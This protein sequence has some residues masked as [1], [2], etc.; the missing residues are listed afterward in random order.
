MMKFQFKIILLLLICICLTSLSNA[1]WTRPII[2][3]NVSNGTLFH[4]LLYNLPW[5]VAGHTIDS[6]LDMNG[7]NL[8]NVDAVR[9]IG[10]NGFIYDKEI[11]SLNPDFYLWRLNDTSTYQGGSILINGTTGEWM[12]TD[13]INKAPLF[14]VNI[15]TALTH[16]YYD[17]EINGTLFVQ[18]NLIEIGDALKDSFL[19]LDGATLK[20]D[21]G[22]NN[23]QLDRVLNMN[24]QSIR[25]D[26]ITV[27]PATWIDFGNSHSIGTEPGTYLDIKGANGVKQYV[28]NVEKLFLENEFLQVKGGLNILMNE[29][30]NITQVNYINAKVVN[31]TYIISNIINAS[32]GN[33]TNL[34]IKAINISN[35]L[36]ANTATI[37]TGTVTT[38]TSTTATL[39][40]A[41]ITRGNILNANITHSN[42]TNT[43]IRNA[44]VTQLNTTNLQVRDNVNITNNLNIYGNISGNQIYGGMYYHNH[45]GTTLNFASSG[46]FYYLYMTNATYVNG[47]TSEGVSFAGSSNLTTVYS[48]LYQASYMASGSGVNNEE[49]YTS[50]FVNNINQDA[51]EN[52]H[53]MN[54]GGDIITQNGFC[55]IRL[56]VGD[57]VSIRTADVTGTGNGVYYSSN[58]NLLRIGN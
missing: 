56:Y 36:R 43:N 20:W 52:H 17:M 7:N 47:F 21:V 45:T 30:N 58:L 12:I 23:I 48:G 26:G 33:F 44:N 24:T 8:T 57:K 34:T 2:V 27:D 29:G 46:V 53:K 39:T 18:G 32:Q 54:A 35:N 4:N 31:G 55:F 9:T 15:I 19:G 49:Y 11:V 16:V 51:C 13:L 40:T 5:S 41:R 14:G 10:D 28:N 42:I 38:L 37:T 25:F 22:D 3:N 6:D 50:I 1:A